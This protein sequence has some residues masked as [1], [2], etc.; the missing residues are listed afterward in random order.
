MKVLVLDDDATRHKTFRKNLI[1]HERVVHVHTY[2]E[3]VEALKHERFDCIFFDHDLNLVGEFKSVVQDPET[4]IEYEM[5]GAD[6][7]RAL[8]E[9]G[10]EWFPSQA[11]VHSYNPSGAQNIVRILREAGIPVEWHL[12]DSES[13]TEIQG[14]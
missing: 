5:T 6:V 10:P 4:G 3:A 12:F 9:A 14:R 2:Q 7:A 1:G 13:G 11:I 8:V